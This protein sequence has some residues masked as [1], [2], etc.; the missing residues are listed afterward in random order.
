MDHLLRTLAAVPPLARILHVGCGD[1]T[2]TANIARLGFEVWACDA[3]PEPARDALAAVLGP[4]VAEARVSRATP[5]SLGFADDTF[6]WVA[7]H[8]E[9]LPTP[10]DFAYVHR[11]MHPGA[12]VW[13]SAP[14]GSPEALEAA[15][16]GAGLAL[17]ERAAADE[18]NGEP[19]VRGIFRRVGD[20][21]RG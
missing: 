4:D 14:A 16:S 17:S 9:A 18:K 15:A 1:G 20:D 5:D 12:W 3:N 13:A 2:L 19:V 21:V 8:F 10:E 6:D 11:V 7:V